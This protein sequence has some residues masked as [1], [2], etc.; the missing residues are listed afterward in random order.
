MNVIGQVAVLFILIIVGYV[1]AKIKIAGPQAA[2]V[3]APII[4]NVTLPCMLLVSFQRPFSKE[5]LGQAGFALAGASLMYGIA[6]LTAFVFPYLFKFKGPERGVH[7]YG[8]IFSNC[9]FIGYPMVEAILGPE[10]LFHA[11]FYNILF[12]IFAFS[13]G[14]WLIAKEG[15]Q[16]IKMSWKTFIN[17]C[18]IATVTGFLFF[19]FS[20]KLPGPLYRSARLAGECTSAMSMLV[21][22]ISLAQVNAR[23]VWGRWRIYVTSFV[24]LVFLP[25]ITGLC[26]WLLRLPKDLLLLTVIIS[27]MPAATTTSIVA[28]LYQTAPGEASALV[29]IST[30]FSMATV[31][32][33]VLAL[34]NLF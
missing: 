16:A 30:L 3:I 19:L 29:F 23:H 6:A 34:G 32:V 28:S 14:A 2:S 10:Y 7:R 24:R 12:N 13:I 26:C 4:I 1:C 20:I 8:L 11:S 25:C 18:V 21:I 22:G 17:P 15:E 33:I 31:P 9:G 27:A 5:L